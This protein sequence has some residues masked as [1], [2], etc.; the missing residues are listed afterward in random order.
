M[1]WRELISRP[2]NP[3]W[4]PPSAEA[5]EIRKAD[6]VIINGTNGEDVITETL[7]GGVLSVTGLAAQVA[8]DGFEPTLDTVRVQGLAGDD[9]VDTSAVGAGGPLLALDGGVGNDILLGGAGN[10]NLL[11]GDNDDVLLGNGGVDTLDGGL[12][13]NTLIQDGGSNITTGIVTLFGDALDNTITISRNAAG[14]ILFNGVPIPGATVANTSLIRVFGQGG[15]DIITF[16]EANGALPS[17]LVFGGAGTDTISGGSGA[18]LLLAAPATTRSS[19][20]A[21]SIFSSAARTT[22]R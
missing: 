1:T 4:L 22:T 6:T 8:V 17:G 11:G 16:D 15:N 18:D 5:L 14:A 21:A 7:T 12:G 20:R 13:D 3:I 9:I 10:D 19:E 2:L